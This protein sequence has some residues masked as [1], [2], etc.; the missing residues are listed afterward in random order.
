[1]NG[2]KSS[3]QAVTSGVPQGSLLG[4]VLFNVFISDLDKGIKCTLSKFVNITKLDRRDDL[5]EG[6]KALQR[7]VD[8]LDRWAEANSM[9]FNKAQCRVLR[10]GHN[11]PRQHYRLGAEWLERCPVQKDLGLSVDSL[12]NISQ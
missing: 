4:P 11:N 1:M 9:R 3:W 10:L 6:R 5:F 2:V 8:R 12:L 7:D